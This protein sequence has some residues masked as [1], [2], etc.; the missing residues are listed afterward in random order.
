MIF[1]SGVSNTEHDTINYGTLKKQN[2][3][4]YSVPITR[5]DLMNRFCE[6]KYMGHHSK[7]VSFRATFFIQNS[8]YTEQFF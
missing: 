8:A 4:E 3:S 5:T 2:I 7:T 1:M 6:K